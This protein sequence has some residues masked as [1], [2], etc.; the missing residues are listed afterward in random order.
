MLAHAQLR[1]LVTKSFIRTD[2]TCL[3]TTAE[4]D[5][6]PFIHTFNHPFIS[7]FCGCTMVV[8][9][10]RHV[11]FLFVIQHSLGRCRQRRRPG[12][13]LSLC[14]CSRPATAAVAAAGTLQTRATR[15]RRFIETIRAIRR[16]TRAM[17]QRSVIWHC[18]DPRN[19]QP[20]G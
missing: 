14:P 13:S 15:A 12:P 1:M 8:S 5:E 20:I 16:A 11:A 17:E 19:P 3:M 2:P 6:Q 4:V 10:S 9:T 18:I 7:L